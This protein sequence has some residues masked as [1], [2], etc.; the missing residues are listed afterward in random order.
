MIVNYILHL[1]CIHDALPAIKILERLKFIYTT[2]II[3]FFGL[4]DN[5]L[6]IFYL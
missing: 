5:D 2:T 4:N 3:T 6:Q 1:N